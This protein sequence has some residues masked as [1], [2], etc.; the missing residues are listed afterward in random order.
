MN[1]NMI[2]RKQYDDYRNVVRDLYYVN[3]KFAAL[4]RYRSSDQE[5]SI[6][7]NIPIRDL[8]T[9]KR[10]L[11]KTNPIGLRFR[12]RGPR[13]D[14]NRGYTLIKHANRFSVYLK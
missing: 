12:Y 5:G 8:S 4:W 2:T 10:L 7:K 9:V 6:F 3:P 11:N 14:L 13:Y 1:Q